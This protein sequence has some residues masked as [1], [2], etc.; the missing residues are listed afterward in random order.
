M[1]F[2]ME[3]K[4]NATF[5]AKRFNRKDKFCSLSTN[6]YWDWLTYIDVSTIHSPSLTLFDYILMLL[7]RTTT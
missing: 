3:K 4:L 7:Y 6:E 5:F 2:N 1:I